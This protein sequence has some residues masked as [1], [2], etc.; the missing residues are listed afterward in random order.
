MWEYVRNVVCEWNVGHLLL[1]WGRIYVV[2]PTVSAEVACRTW[3]VAEYRLDVFRARDVHKQG[4]L[5]DV[6][7][8]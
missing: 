7:K 2:S 8:R 4:L 1:L 3:D 5:A 6:G